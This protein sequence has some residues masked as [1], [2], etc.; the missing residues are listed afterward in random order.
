MHF[1]EERRRLRKTPESHSDEVPATTKAHLRGQGRAGQGQELAGPKM[2]VNHSGAGGST[3]MEEDLS[4]SLVLHMVPGY[5]SKSKVQ[6]SHAGPQMNANGDGGDGGRDLERQASLKWKV[7]GWSHSSAQCFLACVNVWGAR[8]ARK[9]L[10]D[11]PAAAGRQVGFG[12]AGKEGLGGSVECSGTDWPVFE[13]APGPSPPRLETAAG[14]GVRGDV[15]RVAAGVRTGGPSW[16]GRGRDG[17]FEVATVC[18][19]CMFWVFLMGNVTATLV[20]LVLLPLANKHTDA[21][22]ISK[23]HLP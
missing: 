17:K 5:R 7:S 9:P 22:D 18:D 1:P 20:L 13:G 16:D 21:F 8:R 15:Q 3:A 10:W 4:N 11:S 23:Y 12:R 19:R 2:Y 6:H 14:R